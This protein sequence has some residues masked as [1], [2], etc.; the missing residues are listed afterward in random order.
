MP[1]VS[2][3]PIDDSPS[4]PQCRKHLAFVA[5]WTC[6]GHWGYDEVRTYECAEHGPVFIGHPSAIARGSAKGPE[7]G[8]DPGDRD[9]L[10]PARLKPLPTLDA[11]AI[12]VPEPDSD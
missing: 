1:E 9:S 10:V 5:S 4:C 8:P 7:S 3:V 6:R 11:D 12:A 2:R